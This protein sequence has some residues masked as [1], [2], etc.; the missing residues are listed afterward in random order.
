MR[1]RI[2]SNGK[3]IKL[4]LPS[5]SELIR[6]IRL[7]SE[8]VWKKQLDNSDINDWLSN[9][10]G[11]VFQKEYE[12]LLALWLLAN[13]VFYNEEEVKHLCKI[14]Y[15]DFIHRLILEEDIN[16]EI[17][18]N[19]KNILTRSRFYS[20]GQPGESSG[21]ILYHFRQESDI[22]LKKFI[23]SLDTLDKA[24]DI[25]V[26]VDDVALS[27]GEKSQAAKYIKKIKNGNQKLNDKRIILLTF[28]ATDEAIS[29]LNTEGI[30]VVNCIT[31]D[32]RHK[33]FSEDS[34][35]FSHFSEHLDNAKK[36]AEFYGDIVKPNNPLGHNDGQFLF[37]FYYNTPDNTLPIFWAEENGWI[38]IRKRYHKNYHNKLINLGKYI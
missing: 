28:I 31:L 36:F 32:N 34:M 30:E 25:I 10:T 11:Q 16:N 6:Q 20:L 1:K 21:Y 4:P 38:P 29:F 7:T 8:I 22:P 35:V 13:F 9:F 3:T 26:F 33:C 17:Q 2:T 12:D 23:T 5:K 18:E 15:K 27:T 19:Y 14:L 24:V 37:G